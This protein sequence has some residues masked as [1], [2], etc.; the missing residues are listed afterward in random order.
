MGAIEEVLDMP[1]KDV[2]G[3]THTPDAIIPGA[4]TNSWESK[5][6]RFCASSKSLTSLLKARTSFS[7]PFLVT[8]TATDTLKL[9][10]RAST[11]P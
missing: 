4:L 7:A 10:D 1:T 6:S 5:L 11:V 9:T 2:L 8:T 3:G